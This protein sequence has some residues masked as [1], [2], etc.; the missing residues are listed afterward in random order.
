VNLSYSPE[1]EAFAQEIRAWLVEH[2]ELP[3]AFATLDDEVAWG[4]QWQAELAADRWVGIHWPHEFGGRG[5]SPV[6][7]AIYNMEYARARAPQPVNR[8]GVNNVGPTIL[9]FGTDEQKRRWVPPILDASEIWCQLFSEPG[10]G[11]DLAA[12]ATKATPVDGGWLL[13]GQKVWTSYAQWARWGICLARTDP[14]APQHR[15]ISYLIVDMEAEGIEIRPLVQLTGEAE[16]NEVFFDDVFV[17]EDHL[18]GDLNR[19]WSV[20]STTLSHERGTIFAFKEQV[21]HEVFLDELYALAHERDLLDDVAASDALAQ[22]FVETRV[23]RL[24]NTRTLSRLAK[25]IEPGPETSW[26]KLAWTD[27]TQALSSRALDLCEEAGPLWRGAH[28]L[29]ADGKWQRQWLWSKAA[30]I[31]GGTSEVQKNIVAERILGLPRG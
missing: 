19:G 24:H 22:S 18:I 28:E 21:V 30:S 1:E 13:N 2:L 7:V 17:P 29:P 31:A 11:S 23:L 25:G 10:A 5:A 9:A 3:P 8:V 6:Q 12:I 4:R 16:F 15:G 14:D 20:A 27:M 26:I